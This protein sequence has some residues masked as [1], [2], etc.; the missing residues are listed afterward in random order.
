[1]ST[2]QTIKKLCKEHQMSINDLER[3]LGYSKNTLYRLKT[4]TPGSDKLKKIADYFQ[5]STDHLLGR[6]IVYRY[7]TNDIGLAVQDIIDSLGTREELQFYGSSI[8][9]TDKSRLATALEVALGICK[10]RERQQGLN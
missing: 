8:D 5:V 3:A 1:M 7:E 4:Q 9:E 2:F 6:P 10:K